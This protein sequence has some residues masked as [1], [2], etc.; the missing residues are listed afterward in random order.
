[1][2]SRQRM[3]DKWQACPK[4]QSTEVVEKGKFYFFLLY[5]GIAGILL[6]VGMLV[7]WPFVILAFVF[8][9]MA[10]FSFMKKPVNR[11]TSCNYK[12]KP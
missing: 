6:W 11:C 7:F 1:M 2:K 10:V 3:L 8:I 12:W 4:C 5:F 9:I